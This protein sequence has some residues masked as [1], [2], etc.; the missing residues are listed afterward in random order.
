MIVKIDFGSA[1]QQRH[2]SRDDFIKRGNQVK[3]A[4]DQKNLFS[5]SSWG[6][7]APLTPASYCS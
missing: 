6:R 7:Q 5:H 2:R 3:T 4:R 1:V